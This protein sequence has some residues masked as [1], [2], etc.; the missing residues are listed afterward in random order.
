[1]GA[2][3]R[4][5][6]RLSVLSICIGIILLFV[7]FQFMSRGIRNREIKL[8]QRN[9]LLRRTNQKLAQA[10]KSVGLGALSGH[11]MHSLKTPLTHLQLIARRGGRK[12]EIDAKELQNVHLNIRELVSESL[13]ALKEFENQKIS[14]QVTDR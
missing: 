2:I 6:L 13:Q 4:Q 9:Q 10:Y 12:K 1:M 7:I 3:D 11:L 14:Y 8:E 5:L